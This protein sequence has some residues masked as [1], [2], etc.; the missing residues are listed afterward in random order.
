MKLITLTVGIFSFFLAAAPS[1]S[2]SYLSRQ[3]T[4]A[5]TFVTI[6]IEDTKNGD[7]ILEGTF[8]LIRKLEKLFS[9]FDEE[10]EISRLNRQKK[11][12]LSQETLLLLKKSFFISGISEGAFDITCKPI[13]ELYRTAEKRNRP[14]TEKEIEDV[15]IHVGWEKVKIKGNTAEIPEKSMI[16]L[17]GIAKGYIVDMAITRLKDRGVKN[18]MVNAGG[19]IYAFGKNPGGKDWQIGIRNPF[20]KN[21]IIRKISVRDFAVAT[22]GDYERYFSIKNKKYGHIVNP[23]T[24]RSVQDFPVSVTVTA[25]DCA[26]A[27]GLAT[28]F[29]VLGAKK[30]IRIADKIDG[31][32]VFIIDANRITYESKNF[33]KFTLP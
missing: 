11:T 20:R 27:D 33:S 8:S 7:E 32:E 12:A 30:S 10:S 3:E 15:L 6:T 5:G 1:A 9:S 22:S 25:P 21:G 31:V 13:T 18:G 24:G 14:P 4:A 19:D 23:A 26:I 2:G 28:A 29:F 17:G 16:D